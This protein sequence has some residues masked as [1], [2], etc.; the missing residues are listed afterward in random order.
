MKR[1]LKA[2]FTAF[3]LS[4]IITQTFFTA[5]CE[6][7]PKNILRFHI[8]ANSDSEE[9]QALKT[10]LLYG[11]YTDTASFSDLL[12]RWPDSVL[13]RIY[14]NYFVFSCS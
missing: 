4:F 1:F 6:E 11:L 14:D 12:S 3:I 9:D 13:P 2:V 7:I 5:E 8:L 10:A